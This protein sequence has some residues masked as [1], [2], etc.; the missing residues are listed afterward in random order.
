MFIFQL[1]FNLSS[2]IF[3]NGEVLS[4]S[5]THWIEILVCGWGSIPSQGQ[6]LHKEFDAHPLSEIDLNLGFP[7]RYTPSASLRQ[8]LRLSLLK[9]IRNKVTVSGEELHNA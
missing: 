2:A 4:I 9:N 7:R 8:R 6:Y 5:F 1:Y 3:V